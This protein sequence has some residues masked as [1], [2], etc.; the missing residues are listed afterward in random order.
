MADME[1]SG[2][3]VGAPQQHAAVEESLGGEKTTSLMIDAK[4]QTDVERAAE[5]DPPAGATGKKN[6]MPPELVSHI[7]GMPIDKPDDIVMPS[8]L[9]G[10]K[11]MAEAL[12]V[13]EEWLEETYREADLLVQRLHAKFLKYQVEIRDELFEKGYVEVDDDYFE[14]QAEI[15]EKERA[16]WEELE[17]KRDP[18]LTYA[19]Y[20]E[21]DIPYDYEEQARRL[22]AL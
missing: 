12:G 4:I 2:E 1:G 5:S 8:F 17:K 10:N 18:T 22:V 7:L 6:R 3:E 16:R 20:S 9:K 11:D 19:D 15:A 13:T 21:Y 14:R